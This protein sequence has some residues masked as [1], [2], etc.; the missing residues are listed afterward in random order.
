MEALADSLP[1][2]VRRMEPEEFVLP[3]TGDVSLLRRLDNLGQWATV[4]LNVLFLL[5]L[6]SLIPTACHLLTAR[7][8]WSQRTLATTW[9][10][11]EIM[12]PLGFFLGFMHWRPLAEARKSRGSIQKTRAA[13]VFLLGTLLMGAELAFIIDQTTIDRKASIPLI[14]ASVAPDT[15]MLLQ[16]MR[17]AKHD[18]IIP[19]ISTKPLLTWSLDYTYLPFT[20]RSDPESRI[21]ES[22]NLS[23]SLIVTVTA[24]GPGYSVGGG[25]LQILQRLGTPSFSI[26]P[27]NPLNDLTSPVVRNTVTLLIQGTYSG[28]SLLFV[29]FTWIDRKSIQRAFDVVAWATESEQCDWMVSTGTKKGT[30]I[31]NGEAGYRTFFYVKSVQEDCFN[32]ITADMQRDITFLLSRLLASRTRIGVGS[33]PDYDTYALVD[34]FSDPF[35]DD[36]GEFQLYGDLDRRQVIPNTALIILAC[37]LVILSFLRIAC[38]GRGGQYAERDFSIVAGALG[39]NKNSSFARVSPAASLS[40][41]T[42]PC[43]KDSSPSSAAEVG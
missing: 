13:S 42:T 43:P 23:A 19:G 37:L 21:A 30:D 9:L 29:P 22:N 24:P 16:H 20:S 41:N 14:W 40:S 18:F 5:A 26:Q 8:A 2:G 11:T 32:T 31:G 34:S 6:L 25:F 3:I 38:L 7:G 39:W 12:D 27:E 1:P 35:S 10:L 17:L 4:G 28:A 33:V 36:S 15:N